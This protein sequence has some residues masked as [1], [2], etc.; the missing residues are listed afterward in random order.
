MKRGTRKFDAILKA[1]TPLSGCDGSADPKMRQRRLLADLCRLI[2][3][4]LDGANGRMPVSVYASFSQPA[5]HDG[6]EL[7]PRLRQTLQS[8][9]AG[10][11]EKQA[12][13]KLGVSQHTV[14]VYVKQLYRKFDVNSRGELLAKW[15]RN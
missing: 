6:G 15:V 1:M 7:S 8:L 10:D 14:H 13:A 12:A 5:A 3:A 9:L 11:S 2:G 4:H